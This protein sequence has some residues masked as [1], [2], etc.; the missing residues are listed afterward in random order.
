V[1]WLDSPHSYFLLHL[2]PVP[3]IVSLSLSSSV[4]IMIYA[5]SSFLFFH[6]V[7]TFFSFFVPLLILSSRLFPLTVYPFSSFIPSFK[8]LLLCR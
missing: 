7:V 3:V 4:R 1:T 2:S 8:F 5:F 6:S